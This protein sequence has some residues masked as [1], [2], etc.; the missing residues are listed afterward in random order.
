MAE[1]RVNKIR[2]LSNRSAVSEKIFLFFF[3]KTDIEGELISETGNE[4][5]INTTKYVKDFKLAK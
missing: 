4:F 5:Q 2:K 1:C 3:K